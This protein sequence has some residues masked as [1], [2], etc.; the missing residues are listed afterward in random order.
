M[1]ASKHGMKHLLI[2]TIAAVILVGGGKSQQSA[3]SPETK[4]AESVAE[5]FQQETPKAKAP[6]I[7]IL[8]SVLSGNIKAIKQ[9]LDAGTD[10]NAKGWSEWTPL[11]RAV[12]EGHKEVA[13]LLIANGADVSAKNRY[14]KTLL[15]FAE[16][17]IAD[18]LRKH[19]AKTGEELKATGN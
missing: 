18:L 7:S 8:N 10:V 4:P 16:D 15:D 2:T 6:V 19:G 13:E 1:L 12:R 5:A 3:P 9:H 14:G 11:Y 17:E